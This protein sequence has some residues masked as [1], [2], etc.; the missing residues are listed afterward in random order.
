MATS[1]HHIRLSFLC[2]SCS[3]VSSLS[4]TCNLSYFL[5]DQP[6]NNKLVKLFSEDKFASCENYPNKLPI[7]VLK[8]TEL[9]QTIRTLFRDNVAVVKSPYFLLGVAWLQKKMMGESVC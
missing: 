9:N 4:V 8:V 7:Y 5:V 1:G 2:I 6:T 3:N